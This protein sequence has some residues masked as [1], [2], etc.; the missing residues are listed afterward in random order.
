MRRSEPLGL[1]CAIEMK[2]RN[3]EINIFSMSALDLFAS[4]LGAFILIS[5][6]L[7][8]YF[9]RV[10]PEEINRL[11][12]GLAETRQQLQKAQAEAARQQRKARG[13]EAQLKKKS[14][15]LAEAR[16]LRI[17][18]LDIVI[19]LDTTGSMKKEVAG[20]RSEIVQLTR[21][22][23]KLSPS[24][25][26]GIIDFKDRCDGPRAVREFPL[27][28]MSAARLQALVAFSRTMSAGG[29]RCNR[30]R[31]EALAAALDK[32]IASDW[33]AESMSRVIVIMSDNPAYPEREAHAIRAARGFAGQGVQS[34]VSVVFRRTR[35]TAGNTERFLRRLA[36]GG[37]G[38]YVR[39]GASF[40]LAILLALAT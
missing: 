17:P 23:Q 39:A 26:V 12:R 40:S 1:R 22:L 3:R 16:K 18:D 4:A 2:N 36:E 28:R 35:R 11:K 33:R 32:A 29:S 7:M 13:L 9:L 34:K 6:V 20:L 30:D 37:N 38:E 10:D 15:E 24:L 14:Q 27:R 19:A 8:P 25:G 31:P 5:M 21:L